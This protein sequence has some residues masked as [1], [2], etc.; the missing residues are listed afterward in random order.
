MMP[1]HPICPNWRHTDSSWMTEVWKIECLCAFSLN[2]AKALLLQSNKYIFTGGELL[3][4][5]WSQAL[6]MKELL[7][8]EENVLLWN[9]CDQWLSISLID[10]HWRRFERHC[11]RI[12]CQ[13]NYIHANELLCRQMLEAFPLFVGIS[14]VTQK[15][16][17]TDDTNVSFVLGLNTMQTLQS[18]HH[19]NMNRWSWRLQPG[20]SS[21]ATCCTSAL[22]SPESARVQKYKYYC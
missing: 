11:H 22:S 18:H 5:K 3:A 13:R 19:R 7:C 16:S 4:G 6:T 15:S 10:S 9:L 21:C 1:S 17:Y 2:L 12:T 14:V 20:C 8:R